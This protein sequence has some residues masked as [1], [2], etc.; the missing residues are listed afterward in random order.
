MEGIMLVYENAEGWFK[1][2]GM[3]SASGRR[4]AVR[5]ISDSLTRQ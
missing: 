5:T 2:E 4:A 1:A 3:H